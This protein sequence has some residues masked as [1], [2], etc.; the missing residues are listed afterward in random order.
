LQYIVTAKTSMLEIQ[1]L[2]YW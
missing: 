1:Q 2:P